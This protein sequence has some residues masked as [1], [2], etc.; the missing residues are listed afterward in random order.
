[1]DEGEAVADGVIVHNDA[2]V[3]YLAATGTGTGEEHEVAALHLPTLDGDVAC[4]LVAR[5]IAN[6]DVAL[7]KHITGKARAVEGVRP[8][9]AAAV[10]RTNQRGGL[11]HDIVGEG[12]AGGGAVVACIQEIEIVDFLITVGL[13]HLGAVHLLGFLPL[14]LGPREIR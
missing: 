11:V 8:L 13:H 9:A 1:M 2:Y 7:A 10:A 14:A 5:G 12:E 3:A 4:V 6:A